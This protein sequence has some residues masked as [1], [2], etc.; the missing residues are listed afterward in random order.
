MRKLLLP[1]PTS[2]HLVPDDARQGVIRPRP[3][4]PHPKG[5]RGRDDPAADPR[6]TPQNRAT[7]SRISCTKTDTTTQGS[8]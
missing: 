7:S 1:R 5:G 2:S 3:L 6:T 4:V 8:R